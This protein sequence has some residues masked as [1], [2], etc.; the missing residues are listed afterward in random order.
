[1]KSDKTAPQNID[2]YIADFPPDVRAMLE[3]VRQTIGQW[4]PGATEAMKY[5]IP[6]FVLKGNL[7][8][9]AAYK[10]HI[11]FYPGASGIKAFEAELSAFNTSKGTVQFPLDQPLP[12]DLIGRIVQYRVRE[13]L[14][15]AAMKKR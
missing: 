7:V 3:Q 12:L 15:K 2:L 4:A 11:G 1:M 5:G 14:E 9:F 8:H 6:T 10:N 13:N